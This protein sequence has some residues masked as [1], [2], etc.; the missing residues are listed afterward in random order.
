MVASR[1]KMFQQ[2]TT[3][4]SEILKLVKNQFLPHHEVLRWRSTKEEDIPIPNT[5]EIMVLSSFFQHGFS[6]PTCEFLRDLLH[7]YEIDLVH[8]NP[9]SIIQIAILVHLCES[10][11]DVPP[12]FPLFKSYFF[13]KYQ[14]NADKRKIIGGVGLKTH[15]R[16]GFLDLPLKNSLK[17]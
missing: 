6:L 3:D 13:L 17:E 4:E 7:Q 1:P 5:N 11:L 8:L 9:N 14:S 2:S 12:N 16:S 15:P 10:F